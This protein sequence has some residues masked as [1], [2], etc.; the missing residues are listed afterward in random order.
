MKINSLAGSQES[1]YLRGGE[2]EKW[3]CKNRQGLQTFDNQGW[4][5]QQVYKWFYPISEPQQEIYLLRGKM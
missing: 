3:Q 4:S 1:H 5:E 2:K